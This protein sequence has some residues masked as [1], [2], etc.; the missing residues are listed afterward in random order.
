MLPARPKMARLLPEVKVDGVSIAH[1]KVTEQQARLA[2]LRASLKG[3]RYGYTKP[4][5]YAM[6]L[7]DGTLWMSDTDMEWH[8]NQEVLQRA[9]GDVLVFGL[10]LGFIIHPMVKK[11]KE[12]RS[13]TVVEIDKRVIGLM[14][15]KIAKWPGGKVTIEHGDGNTWSTPSKFNVIYFDIWLSVNPDN[16]PQMRTLKA[17]YRKNLH[18]DD[19]DRWIGCWREAECRWFDERCRKQEKALLGPL[20]GKVP[21]SVNGIRL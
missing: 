11:K 21:L 3:E 12:V 20:G 4:G 1:M 2:A 19:P 14:E 16:W 18:K 6:L 13:V 15:P 5:R 17:R 7:V 8:T 10:G 9:H